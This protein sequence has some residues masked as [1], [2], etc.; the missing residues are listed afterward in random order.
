MSL[1]PPSRAAEQLRVLLKATGTIAVVGA[2]PDPARDSH[3]VMGYL[4]RAGY[5]VWP[6]NPLAAGQRIHGVTVVPSLADLREPVEMIDVFRRS[7]AVPAV[8]DEAITQ[9]QRL[10][11]KTIWLQ[12]G[13]RDDA[14][15][16]RARDAGFN[17]VVDRCL[18]VVHRQLL[19][20]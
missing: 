1:L 17:V 9:R 3:E 14:A 15:V 7:D 8:I 10:G 4:L 13:V 12:L 19:G 6:V 16:V 20:R 11:L 2:S 5:R 18:M